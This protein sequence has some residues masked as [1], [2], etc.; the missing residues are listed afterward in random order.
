MTTQK[1]AGEKLKGEIN[2]ISGEQKLTTQRLT[3]LKHSVIGKKKKLG[4]F[5]SVDLPTKLS[6]TETKIA[7]LKKYDHEGV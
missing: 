7:E 3:Q 1:T 2:Q 5:A 6:Q 4:E